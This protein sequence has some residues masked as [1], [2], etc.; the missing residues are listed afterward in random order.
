MS[1]RDELA[2]VRV[3]VVQALARVDRALER[4]RAEVARYEAELARRQ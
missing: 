1:R 4:E 3:I 2:R